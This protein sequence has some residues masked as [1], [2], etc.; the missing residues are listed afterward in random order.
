[1]LTS[2]YNTDTVLAYKQ[3]HK[4]GRFADASTQPVH[5][6]PTTAPSIPIGA[7]CEIDSEEPGLHKRGTVRFVGLTKF[8][9]GVWVG[10]EYDEPMGKNDGS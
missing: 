3:Q 10:I 1:M 5:A 4:V 2:L 7:R 9:S 8:A 6:A